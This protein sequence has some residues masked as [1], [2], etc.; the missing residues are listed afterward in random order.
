MSLLLNNVTFSGL[1]QGS[2]IL[3]RRPV[4][5]ATIAAGTLATDFENGDI[6]DGV[7]L[8]TNDRI[9]IKNQAT[10]SENGIYVVEAVGAPTRADDYQIGD[11]A[12]S[13][14]VPVLLGTTNKASIFMCTNTSPT[15]IIG[16]DNLVFSRSDSAG[17]ILT[18][19]KGGTG[20]GTLTANRFLVGNGTSAVDLTKVVPTGTVVG[21]SDSQTL[22]IGRASCRE[23]VSEC[24]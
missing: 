5:A 14:M 13:T 20:L 8:A 10:A 3:F 19:D 6:I 15:D 7:T 23:R 18:V 17:G 9:L 22:K 1:V 4:V 2:G 16:T 21:T 12:G 24:V 11:L